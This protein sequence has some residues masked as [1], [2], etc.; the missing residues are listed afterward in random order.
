M[1]TVSSC[2]AV[3]DICVVFAGNEGGLDFDVARVGEEQKQQITMRNKGRREI[4]Y[5]YVYIQL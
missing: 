3:S 4:A 1:R 5:S 2:V